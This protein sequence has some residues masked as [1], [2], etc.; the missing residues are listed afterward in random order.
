[1][2]EERGAKE[3]KKKGERLMKGEKDKTTLSVDNFLKCSLRNLNFNRGHLQREDRSEKQRKFGFDTARAITEVR[4]KRQQ[5]NQNM[6]TFKSP[7]WA[8]HLGSPQS[9][10]PSV[11]SYPPI[12]P[13]PTHIHIH[14]M[15]TE[16]EPSHGDLL[17]DR[18]RRLDIP[19]DHPVPVQAPP[20]FLP[21]SAPSYD[22]YGFRSSSGRTSPR[23]PTADRNSP[24]PDVNG[25]GWPGMCLLV[26]LILS[27]PRFLNHHSLPSPLPLLQSQAKSTLS[28]LNASPAENAARQKRLAAAVRTV[29]EC[30]GEDPD[31][32]GLLRTPER[33]AQALM[34]MTKGYEERLP[35]RFFMP[36]LHPPPPLFFF[37]S[38]VP[39]IPT[40]KD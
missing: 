11:R 30:I 31:R 3:K 18:L 26:F 2:D 23:A 16:P 10:P 7:L 33:Y 9:C 4:A 39:S 25:L 32:E 28:R 1:M 17:A 21:K 36:P 24:L 20:P 8:H 35:G 15:N 6:A 13:L 29:L 34:W 14:T 22:G 12:S 27:H 5:S 40:P 19:D 38:R 37:P